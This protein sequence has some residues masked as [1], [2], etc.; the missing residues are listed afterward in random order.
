MRP[1]TPQ[2]VDPAAPPPAWAEALPSAPAPGGTRYVPLPPDM[3]AEALKSLSERLADIKP[4]RADLPAFVP[5]KGAIV[6]RSVA[7]PG[8]TPAEV[9]LIPLV[10]VDDPLRFNA[11]SGQYEGRIKVG[12]AGLQAGDGR[13]LEG[14]FAFEVIGDVT[15]DPEV[16]RVGSVSPPFSVFK[17][18]IREP[19]EA[20]ELRVHSSVSRL[21][22]SLTLPVRRAQLTLRAKTHLQGW[23]LESTEITVAGSDREASRGDVVLLE[24]RQGRGNLDDVKLVLGADGTASTTLRSESTGKVEL[25]ATSARMSPASATIEYDFPLRFLMAALVGG[26]GGGL[27]RR[28]PQAVRGAGRFARELFLGVICGAVVFGLFALGVDLLPFKLPQHGGELV[29][30]VVAALGAYFGT[31]LLDSAAAKPRS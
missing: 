1:S 24:L 21:P 14:S 23:G 26:I 25:V 20:V 2:R 19:G 3:A 9:T 22:V 13:K 28:G 16:V 27:L 15:T 12:L 7:A 5:F 6:T 10:F 30:A 31:R 4:S 17:V 8:E 18:S 11:A 29:V